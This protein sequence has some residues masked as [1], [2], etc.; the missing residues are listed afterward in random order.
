MDATAFYNHT[1]PVGTIK[2][3]LPCAIPPGRSTSPRLPVDWTA[4]GLGYE[5]IRQALGG[6][7][8]LDANATCGVRLGRWNEKVWFQGRGIGSHVR[9]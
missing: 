6:Q 3:D 5:A 1:E 8:K 9:L 2:Y 4:D 7:L